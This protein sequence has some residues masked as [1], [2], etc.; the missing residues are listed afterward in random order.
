[1][2]PMHL[3]D[4]SK[5]CGIALSGVSIISRSTLAEWFSRLAS[6]SRAAAEATA[7]RA[8]PA[9]NTPIATFRINIISSFQSWGAPNESLPVLFYDES[10]ASVGSWPEDFVFPSRVAD[11]PGPTGI[12]PGFL[13]ELAAHAPAVK[14]CR[15]AK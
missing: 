3:A 15:H 10:T 9:T 8:N 11:D 2:I 4:A 1:M 6:S 14:E 13:P 12:S 5:P 7:G